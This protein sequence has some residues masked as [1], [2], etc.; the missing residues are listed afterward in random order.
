MVSAKELFRVENEV[1]SKRK[2][3]VFVFLF[4]VKPFKTLIL[5]CVA[6][7][8]ELRSCQVVLLLCLVKAKVLGHS[9]FQRTVVNVL[10]DSPSDTVVEYGVSLFLVTNLRHGFDF[11]RRFL[12]LH[13]EIG[14]FFSLLHFAYSPEVSFY[15]FVLLKHFIEVKVFQA[16]EGIVHMNEFKI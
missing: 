3:W 5:I 11:P 14:E 13:D 9:I 7:K 16:V 10:K 4:L 6:I 15:V 12:S 1:C 8:G 2:T